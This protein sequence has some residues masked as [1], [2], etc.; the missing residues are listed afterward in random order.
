MSARAV[1]VTRAVRRLSRL[2]PE[3]VRAVRFGRTRLGRRG[4][5]EEQV[6]AFVRQVVDELIARD[7]AEASLREE[8][9]RLKGALREWQAR[10]SRSHPDNAGHWT[11]SR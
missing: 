7:A 6:Y 1:G 4:L 8:N 3:Q 10:H 11:D 9:T 2:R 5:A